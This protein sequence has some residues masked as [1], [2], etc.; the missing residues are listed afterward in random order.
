MPKERIAMQPPF[1][2]VVLRSIETLAKNHQLRSLSDAEL[3]RQFL[4]D[5]DAEA[6][7]LI[8]H[9][10]GP[11]VW[12]VCR[13]LLPQQQDAEDAFQATFLV[14][15]DS[16]NTIRSGKVLASWLHGV[17]YRVATKAKRS[18]VR[19]KNR[20]QKTSSQE[21][22]SPVSEPTWDQLQT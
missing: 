17:A 19:R 10:H 8:V 15:I 9:R 12:R 6:F 3:L 14:L 16:A 11:Y 18:A 21:T 4:K 2:D 5:R 20:E 22:G 13:S 1:L 7:A